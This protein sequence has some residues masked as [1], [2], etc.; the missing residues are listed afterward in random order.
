MD[1]ITTPFGAASTAAE[2][3]AGID[4]TGRRAV[5]TGGASGIGVETAR[6]LAGA[7]A[8]VTLAVRDHDAGQARRRGHRRAPPA[9]S[10]GPRR[11][12]RPRRPGLRRRVRPQLGRAAAHP[13]QQRRRDGRAR[14]TRTPRAGSCSSPP[15]TS[16]TS[17]WP[18]ACTT[19]LAA[20]G[21]ARSSSVSSSAH[22]RVAVVFDDIHFRERA[23]D[24]G[25]R[26]GSRRPPTCCSRSR[27]AERWAADGITV[28]AL[29]PGG[30]RTTLQRHW[31]RRANC[32]RAASRR[33]GAGVRWKTAEQGAATSVLVAASP[34]LDGDRR[35]VLR[36]LRRGR[37]ATGRGVRRRRALRPGPRG[38]ARLWEVSEQLLAAA[39]AERAATA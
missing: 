25:R 39:R 1:L 21:D 14:W 12:A 29:M 9:T 19:A 26:T 10:R 23:Y 15:T 18:R 35:P 5:V 17:H 20:A 37:V 4:L 38:G 24:P 36:G 16:A 6:A 34:L 3:V 13:G 30:I 27:R 7:G 32:G 31:S 28:N 2:V 33:A 22:L 8:A 11:P